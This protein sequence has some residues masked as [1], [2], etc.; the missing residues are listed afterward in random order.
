MNVVVLMGRLCADPELKYTSANIPVCSFRLAVDRAYKSGGE[1]KTDFLNVT[2]WRNTAEFVSRYFKK[3]QL[4][5]LEG[6]LETHTYTDKDGNNRTAYE[7]VA[8]NVH[9]AESK[10]D[11]NSAQPTRYNDSPPAAFSNTDTSDFQEI[12]GVDEDDLPF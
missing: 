2:A 5:A 9:F 1:R 3:G 10:R 8:N 6:S 7:I 12:V 4:I 11:G